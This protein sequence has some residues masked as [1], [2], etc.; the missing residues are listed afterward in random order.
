MFERMRANRRE[1]SQ[2]LTLFLAGAGVVII[3][4][5]TFS[6]PASNREEPIGSFDLGFRQGHA[7]SLEDATTLI[8]R[9]A[10]ASYS[11]GLVDGANRRMN[12]DGE[13]VRLLA[14]HAALTAI[15]VVNGT[16]QDGYNLGVQDGRTQAGLEP[17]GRESP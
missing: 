5:A 15:A 11:R 2:L 9:E 13:A 14:L 3:L 4:A 1:L 12:T 6:W 16:Y 7:Q 8:D 10:A 17:V